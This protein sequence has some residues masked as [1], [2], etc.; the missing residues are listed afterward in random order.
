MI[1]AMA[2]SVALLVSA[3][4]TTQVGLT[5]L[6]GC[7]GWNKYEV[8]LAE[9]IPTMDAGEYK[10]FS[11][12]FGRLSGGTPT[13]PNNTGLCRQKEPPT[14]TDIFDRSVDEAMGLLRPLV[15]KYLAKE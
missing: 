14:G 9:K 12:V 1:R 3:C 13:M 8:D 5:V 10:V 7:R 6:T 2:I 15:T 11:E 4:S